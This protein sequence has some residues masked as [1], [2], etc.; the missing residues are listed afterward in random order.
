MKDTQMPR[1]RQK[2]SWQRYMIGYFLVYTTVSVL[3]LL[4]LGPVGMSK[5][6]LDEFKPDHDRYIE[7]IKLKEYKRWN[8]RPE[9][10]PPGEDLAARIAFVQEYA[11][12]P[13]FIA[14]KKRRAIYGTLIDLFNVAMVGILVVHFASKPLRQF[15]DNTIDGV[16][17]TMERATDDFEDAAQSKADAQ[18]KLDALPEQQAEIDEKTAKRIEEMRRGDA[19]NVGERL[20]NLNRETE[21]RRRYEQTLARLQLKQ[22]LVNQAIDVLAERYRLRTTDPEDTT[23]IDRF[24]QQLEEGR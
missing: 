5:S 2:G 19:L 9:L 3:L 18:A 13:E 14:E 15:L 12:R 11:S 22:E 16:R 1:W 10:N 7:T 23:L 6:Y 24:V 21:D 4:A 17:T 8:Q 20:A